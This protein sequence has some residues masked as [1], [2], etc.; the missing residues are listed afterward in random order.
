MRGKIQK[1]ASQFLGNLVGPVGKFVPA[2][3]RSELGEFLEG[4]KDRLIVD[5][6]LPAAFRDQMVRQ[7]LHPLALIR[8]LGGEG[9]ERH[10]G[11]EDPRQNLLHQDAVKPAE[12][13][14]PEQHPQHVFQ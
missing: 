14:Q 9:F 12:K 1:Q 10:A 5:V 13:H 6:E 3:R 8:D 4:L 11:G 7:K 2:G